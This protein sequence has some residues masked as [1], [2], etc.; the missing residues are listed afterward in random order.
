MNRNKAMVRVLFLCGIACLGWRFWTLVEVRSQ[1]GM[2]RVGEEWCFVTVMEL[3]EENPLR[4]R[5]L[6][7]LMP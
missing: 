1:N 4:F 3:P 7:P 6:P 5:F 2:R